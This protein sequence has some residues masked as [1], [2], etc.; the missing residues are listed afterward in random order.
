MSCTDRE[1]DYLRDLVLAQTAN[2]VAPSR[3]ALFETRL[4]S[5]ARMAGA[6]SL[7]DLVTML[8]ANRPA[9]LHRA[10]SEAMTVN[11]TSFFRDL[12]PW[13]AL[14][15]TVIPNLIAQNQESRRLRFWSAGCSTGQEGYSLAMMLQES[16]PELARWDV[17]IFGTDISAPVAEYARDGRYRRLEVNRGLP[18]K[19]LMRYF[20]RAGDQWQVDSRTRGLCE[21]RCAN[22]CDAP[23]SMPRFDLVLLRNVLLY[24]PPAERRKVLGHVY[25]QMKPEGYLLLGNAEQAEDSCEMFRAEFGAGCYFYRP[26]SGAQEPDSVA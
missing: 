10:V 12:W 9:R 11:E 6:N 1:Y 21:F 13:E 25:R 4:A 7:G 20:A 17:K 3:N 19:M 16:F 18:A 15:N 22:L 2:L 24:F 14:R 5:V 23:K 26:A 8:Q